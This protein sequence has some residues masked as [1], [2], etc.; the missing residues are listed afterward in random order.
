MCPSNARPNDVTLS[1]SRHSRFEYV[2]GFVLRE[3][4]HMRYV[5]LSWRMI[6]ARVGDKG[7]NFCG[8]R[9]D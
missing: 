2:N 7:I 9:A 5:L 3:I 8:N 6:Q 4:C 1:S